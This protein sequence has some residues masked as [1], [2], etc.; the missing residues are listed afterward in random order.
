MRDACLD[1][2]SFSSIPSCLTS[3]E[4]QWLLS[5]QEAVLDT[6]EMESVSPLC[7]HEAFAHG[8]RHWQ[9]KTESSI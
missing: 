5:F 3:Q 9:D 7:Y 2:F 4:A 8:V 1:L 6:L